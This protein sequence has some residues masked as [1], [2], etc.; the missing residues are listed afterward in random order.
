[1]QIIIFEDN[2]W[3]RKELGQLIRSQIL[4]RYKELELTLSTGD[5]QSV[6]RFLGGNHSPAIFLLD[7]K[8]GEDDIDFLLSE[9]IHRQANGSYIIFI[10]KYASDWLETLEQQFYA[11]A[12]IE[13]NW[14]TAE[15]LRKVFRAIMKLEGNASKG[16][17][18]IQHAIGGYKI[19]YEKIV[20]IEKIK[21]R[22]KIRV[23]TLDQV[24]EPITCPHSVGA[25]LDLL[26][27]RFIRINRSTIINADECRMRH[28]R[29]ITM[30]NGLS[31]HI[32][33]KYREVQLP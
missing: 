5:V 19:A 22:H 26:D 17:F 6:Y 15:N 25:L 33:K 10:T 9:T 28:G 4:P 24:H 3:D 31:Y 18:L 16:Y 11:T 14:H 2:D 12:C 1:M 7:I 27:D 21:G 13:K 29:E 32:T 30:T 20:S 23:F 8:V